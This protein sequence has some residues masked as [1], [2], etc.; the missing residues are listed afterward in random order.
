MSELPM[1]KLLAPLSHSRPFISWNKHRNI[2]RKQFTFPLFSRAQ[3]FY[4]WAM[5]FSFPELGVQPIPRHRA[6]ED[7][8]RSMLGL[9]METEMKP[10]FQSPFLG[11]LK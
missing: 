1:V 4:S 9:E 7:T 3:W 6:L 11:E 2:C 5:L 8:E 10:C